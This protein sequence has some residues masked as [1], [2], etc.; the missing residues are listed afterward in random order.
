MT[1]KTLLTN[2][3]FAAIAAVAMI[4]TALIYSQVSPAN[5]A[6]SS[7]DSFTATRTM[8]GNSITVRPGES[9][10]F[11]LNVT[12]SRAYSLLHSLS[13]G[14]QITVDP[15]F[16]L[17]GLHVDSNSW[18]ARWRL[19]DGT[20]ESGSEVVVSPTT[21]PTTLVGTF[22]YSSDAA[23]ASDNLWYT[24]LYVIFRNQGQN[25]LTGSF[26]PIVTETHGG[27]T[28]TLSSSDFVVSTIYQGNAN[29]AGI[30]KD[31]SVYTP[32]SDDISVTTGTS[33]LC[34][35]RSFAG[36][37]FFP[38]T[39]VLDDGNALSRGETAN[40]VAAVRANGNTLQTGDEVTGYYFYD[41]HG[42]MS[43]NFV[44]AH[45]LVDAT[46]G[47][48]ISLKV[49]APGVYY[50]SGNAV[51][52]NG[53]QPY[54]F[55]II[56]AHTVRL[57]GGFVSTSLSAGSYGDSTSPLPVSNGTAVKDDSSGIQ[58]F[59]YVTP[60]DLTSVYESTNVTI[61]NPSD[62]AAYSVTTSLEDENGND[63]T[64]QCGPAAPT[65]TAG[66]PSSSSVSVTVI[67]DLAA[68]QTKCIAYQNGVE[69]F[70]GYL[71]SQNGTCTISGLTASTAYTIKAQSYN[72][73]GWGPLTATALN[74]TTAASSGGGGGGGGGSQ[75][76]SSA[77]GA[78][79]GTG[80]APTV[81]NG[82]AMPS[83]LSLSTDGTSENYGQ[84]GNGGMLYAAK[85]SVDST[86]YD[87]THLKST[88]GKDTAFGTAGKVSLVADYV[89]G[90]GY[91]GAPSAKT[92]ASLIGGHSGMSMTYKIVSGKLSGGSITTKSVTLPSSI[93]PSGFSQ[94]GISLIP[95]PLAKP[96]AYVYCFIVPGH[97]TGTFTA[98]TINPSS[99]AV[100][101]I[102]SIGT[103]PTS[104]STSNFFPM[105]GVGV[106]PGAT[107]AQVALSFYVTTTPTT[108]LSLPTKREIVNITQAGTLRMKTISGSPWGANVE[109]SQVALVPGA[110]GTAAWT[111]L[112]RIMNA[113]V[114]SFKL[115]TVKADGTLTVGSNV[116][117]A[118][119]DSYTP[120]R[121]LS[122]GYLVAKKRSTD[123]T[124]H[125]TSYSI[126]KVKLT[127][128]AVTGASKSVSVAT[129]NAI[130]RNIGSG[131]LV[132][133]GANISK[134]VLFSVTSPTT[135]ATATWTL[136][137]S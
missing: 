58:L 13:T 105:P 60:S 103:V 86:K 80:T 43:I 106:N 131:S 81:A 69:A 104:G 26:A 67:G 29:R 16:T 59:G 51:A 74:V 126:A 27:S 46:P 37:M 57:S 96:L 123:P 95:S 129:F 111:G 122:S 133:S 7:A 47:Q 112:A 92:W 33:N 137:T 18:T 34:L 115:V 28:A 84:D 82:Q 73:E 61:D 35:D 91:Y 3:L 62:A 75:P 48:T 71:Y 108:S 19:T 20:S 39:D 49:T 118:T 53:T 125:A 55:R 132:M 63:V 76:Y 66:T 85:D 88:G 99:G 23:T 90:L 8:T 135:Y 107:G 5:A 113:G 38:H 100:T 117:V 17:N 32:S 109:P 41:D 31:G 22:T 50:D 79:T 65:I 64:R 70:S 114:L 56:D 116:A 1:I 15:H 68:T 54:T 21:N 101:K 11:N 102:G 94:Q 24:S 14:D 130:Q 87:I 128:G 30:D 36:S 124:T 10:V 6:T 83:G 9:A 42:A 12:R 127:N 97:M 4:A 119:T 77:F 136:P 121:T 44:L 45:D 98:I 134:Y 110:T 2:R 40:V 72:G 120:I 78:G 89:S 52:A 25:T 93:C